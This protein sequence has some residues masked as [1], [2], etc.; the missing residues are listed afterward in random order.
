MA[1][2]ISV[3]N[4]D[5]AK[6]Y[7]KAIQWDDS[8]ASIESNGY[9][10]A[11]INMNIPK[12]PGDKTLKIKWVKEKSTLIEG[13]ATIIHLDKDSA[14]SIKLASNNPSKSFLKKLES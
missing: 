2:Y 11:G 3:L 10:T 9:Y 8:L 1:K 7:W 12:Q 13:A 5:L 6:T 4:S 14:N